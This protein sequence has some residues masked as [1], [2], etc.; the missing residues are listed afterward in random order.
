M[1]VDL[2]VPLE[3]DALLIVDPYPLADS[4]NYPLNKGVVPLQSAERWLS[5]TVDGDVKLQHH[6]ADRYT[7]WIDGVQQRNLIEIK[8]RMSR[9]RAREENVMA[10]RRRQQHLPGIEPGDPQDIEI[11]IPT[12]DWEQIGGDMDPGT[13]GGIIATG[14]G[15]ALE[16]IVIQPVREHVGDEEAKD[17]GFP[18][19]TKEA[20]FD[21]ANLDPTSKDA[22]SA[23]DSIGMSLETLEEDFT[24]EA[25]A[26]V[27]AEALLGWGRG[28]EGPAG[29]SGDINI[30]EKV[31]WSSGKIAGPEYLADEDEAFRDD[32]LGYG[33]IKTAL[34]E[35][36][37]RLA[38]ESSATGWS[39]VGDQ[40]TS[41]IEDAGFD[42]ASIVILAEFGDATAVNG[43]ITDETVH[44]VEGKLEPEGYEYLDRF[45]GRVPSEEGYAHAD[46]A[47]EAVAKELDRSEEDVRTAAESL[48]WWQEEI[49]RGTSGHTYVWAKRKEEHRTEEARRRTRARRR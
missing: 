49:P 26:I 30:P 8:V 31:K 48:D 13:Y 47:I 1:T 22:K 36:V 17:V 14:D 37:E 19:W 41:D 2:S 33:E 39:T 24:P 34:E 45:G 42:P 46:S 5:R 18:F 21:L 25:R 9:K 3:D 32:V 29:W 11:V 28:D 38:D 10:S 43:D 27:I 16:L 40:L 6:H 4:V 15:N 7:T 20:Y 35:E 12:M 23:L 44:A